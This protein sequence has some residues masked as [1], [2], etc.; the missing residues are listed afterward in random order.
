MTRHL[1]SQPGSGSKLHAKFQKGMPTS[2]ALT[3]PRML[4]NT[5]MLMM[6]SCKQP[7]LLLLLSPV[8]PD[9]HQVIVHPDHNVLL[10]LQQPE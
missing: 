6:G 10:G 1:M 5:V 8:H 3:W 9:A 4:S 2:L 7:C